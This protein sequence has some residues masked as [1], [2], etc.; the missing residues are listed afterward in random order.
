MKCPSCGHNNIAGEDFCES[1]QADL[2]SFDGVIPKTKMERV[3]MED[4]LAK[5]KPK[6]AICVSED[7]SIYD[8]VKKMNEIKAGCV[9]VQN[10]SGAFTGIVTERD[11]LLRAVGTIPNLEKTKVSTIMTHNPDTL[12]EEDTLAYALHEM[13][14]KNYRHIP[15]LRAEKKIGVI[16]AR[17]VLNYLAK[18]FP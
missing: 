13:S 11:I 7:T 17:D 8:A 6:E 5:L 14:V 1:C 9:F 16:T 18:L 3:L 4:H 2:T 10:T 15:V 12:D